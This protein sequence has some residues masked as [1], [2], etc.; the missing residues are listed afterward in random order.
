MTYSHSANVSGSFTS[1]GDNGILSDTF[2]NAVVGN[3]GGANES[4]PALSTDT[5]NKVTIRHYD[6]GIGSAVT[7]QLQVFYTLGSD[8]FA[9]AN[10]LVPTAETFTLTPGKTLSNMSL[11]LVANQS[12]TSFPIS[13]TTDFVMFFEEQLTLPS[14]R[15]PILLRK[16]RNVVEL[17]IL[18]REGGILQDLGSLAAEITV[19][20]SLITTTSPNA[21]SADQ[22]WYIFNGLTLETGTLQSD[23]NPSWQWFQ[24]DQIGAKV[25]VTDWI[26]QQPMGR[27]QF[28][29]YSLV[30]KK[31]DVNGETLTNDIGPFQY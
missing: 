18:G 14:V 3:Y 10:S 25:L 19:A 16:R 22:W 12:L 28:W 13:L 9:L 30:M 26:P 31:F 2:T 29:D 5:F 27:V 20:G 15:Q 1:D 4:L 17:P 6:S 8:N 21:W 11:I 24:S 23:G 7:A